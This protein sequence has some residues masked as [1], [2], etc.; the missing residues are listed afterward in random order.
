MKFRVNLLILVFCLICLNSAKKKYHSSKSRKT[1]L[2]KVAYIS[3][4][5]KGERITMVG[6]AGGGKIK[7]NMPPPY[8]PK[9]MVNPSRQNP[10]VV[11]PEIIYPRQKKRMIIHHNVT[12]MDYYNEKI[13]SNN[14]NPYYI[15]MME[16][17][18]YWKPFTENNEYYQSLLE[19]PMYKDKLKKTKKSMP[20]P[21]KLI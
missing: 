7:L 19:N 4:S 15:Q 2:K 10:I 14:I 16:N 13:H 17:N 9:V 12:M 11:V 5:N 8:Y 20:P 1:L 6:G 3:K 18:P 21:K